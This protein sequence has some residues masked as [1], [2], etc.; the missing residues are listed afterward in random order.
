MSPRANCR[1][2]WDDFLAEEERNRSAFAR[3]HPDCVPQPEQPDL[4]QWDERGAPPTATASA[5]GAYT[6]AP[7]N[8]WS[9]W[10]LRIKGGPQGG[11][12][13][14]FVASDDMIDGMGW[15]AGHDETFRPIDSRAGLGT[16]PWHP[17]DDSWRG[18]PLHEGDT[19]SD[20]VYRSPAEMR[21]RANASGGVNVTR[22]VQ[23]ERTAGYAVAPGNYRGIGAI[24]AEPVQHPMLPGHYANGGRWTMGPPP[25]HLPTEPVQHPLL[26]AG[27][28]GLTD[29]YS[30]FPGQGGC[31]HGYSRDYSGQC[32]PT[33][34]QRLAPIDYTDPECRPDY[35]YPRPQIVM[36]DQQCW[37]GSV[38]SFPCRPC[39]PQPGG[40]SPIVPQPPPPTQPQPSPIIGTSGCAAG[41]YRDAAG[42]CTTDWTNPYPLYLPTDGGSPAP[43]PTVPA[44]TCQTGFTQDPVTGNCL[45][46]GQYPTAPTAGATSW[47]SASTSIAGMNIPNLVLAGI[48]GIVAMKMMGK[49]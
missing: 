41:Q 40:P 26:P 16:Y 24:P 22:A 45:G 13:H 32:V 4:D 38:G 39:P 6:P 14:G 33:A 44:N 9:G 15:P 49:K 48:F 11:Q 8:A 47:F 35:P 7:Y 37:D 46:P 34:S 23:M 28:P 12:Y 27:P 5:L 36:P 1:Q 29:P 30:A 3:W 20:F 25:A 10:R 43:S 2:A 21:P 17:W 31:Q 42:N 18:I 19:V